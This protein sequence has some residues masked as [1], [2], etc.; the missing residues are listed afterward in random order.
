MTRSVSAFWNRQ[1]ASVV[2]SVVAVGVR[3][4]CSLNRRG[5]ANM[6]TLP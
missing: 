1:V 5:A 2:A 4:T 3:L 6:G